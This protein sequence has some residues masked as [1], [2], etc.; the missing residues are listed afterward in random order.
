MLSGFQARRLVRTDVMLVLVVL[1]F[2]VLGLVMVKSASYGFAL[3]E[4]GAFEGRPDYFLERQAVFLVAGLGALFVVSRLDYRLWR[5]YALHILGLSVAVLLIMIVAGRDRGGAA[6]WVY[7]GSIQPV[8]FAKL[9]VMIY[10]AAWLASRG[11]QLRA[12]TGLGLLAFSLLLGGVAALILMQP[13]FSTV[14]ILLLTATAMFF[15]AGARMR[16]IVI[17]LAGGMAASYLVVRASEYRYERWVAFIEGPFADPTGKGMQLIQAL[18][19]LSRGGLFG[20]GL[21]QSQQK[22]VIYAPHT[23]GIF[24]IIG[25]ELGVLGA[26]AVV[27]LYGVWVWRGMR[28][29]WHA[30]DSYGRLLA[31]GITTWVAF[32]AAVHMGVLTSSLPFTGTVLPMVSYGGS[33]L[34]STLLG[35]GLL[36]SIS[37]AG[38]AR[39]EAEAP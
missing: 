30:P 33:S 18:I 15:A 6:R 7:A 21:G 22:F 13:D 38:G 39:G 4:G 12:S 11:E 34:T 28:I 31:V 1:A 20:V 29:A 10:I 25:E 16:Q 27:G 37:R 32:Q 5:R 9:G 3:F 17:L 14:V 2:S 8:E 26:L 19:A 23:D 36:L 24:A 35:A